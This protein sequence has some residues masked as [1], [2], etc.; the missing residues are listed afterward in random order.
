MVM[1]AAAGGSEVGMRDVDE[2]VFW[3]SGRR[4]RQLFVDV[5]SD[6][7]GLLGGGAELLQAPFGGVQSYCRRLLGVC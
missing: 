6:R 7:K 4:L 5:D 2:E 1:E 3:G